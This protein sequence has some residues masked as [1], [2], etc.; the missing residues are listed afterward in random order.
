[1]SNE[2]DDYKVGYGRPPLQSR[3]KKGKSGNPKGRKKGSKGLKTLIAEELYRP[4]EIKDSRGH[5][6]RIPLIQAALRGLGARSVKD[7]R[8]A[9]VA[10]SLIDRLEAADTASGLIDMDELRAADLAILRRHGYAKDGSGN[11]GHDR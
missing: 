5:V 8:A 9:I 7:N 3:F 2:Q 11:D 4:V 6:K 1:M 10:L